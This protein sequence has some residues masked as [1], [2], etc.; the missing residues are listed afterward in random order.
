MIDR[1]DSVGKSIKIGRHS[2][3]NIFLSKI[4]SLT[5]EVPCGLRGVQTNQRARFVLESRYLY[6]K[7]FHEQTISVYEIT[8]IADQIYACP[9]AH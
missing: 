2:R 3:W 8:N 6:S 1:N 4:N 9:A 7:F 5:R